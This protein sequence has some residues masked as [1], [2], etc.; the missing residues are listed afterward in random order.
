[1]SFK[2]VFWGVLLLTIGL[3]YALRNFDVIWFSWGA[4]VDLWPLLLLLWGVSLLPVK[5]VFKL[6]GSLGV[7]V[8]AVVLVL[9]HPG[10]DGF[11]FQFGH[12]SWH[13]NND[14]QYNEYSDSD[15][16]TYSDQS[17]S[18]PL[19]HAAPLVKLQLNAAAGRFELSDT[20][21]QLIEFQSNGNI[22][23]YTMTPN[24]GTP[25]SEVEI[26]LD[27]VSVSSGDV[28]NEVILKLNS[29]VTWMIDVEAGASKV[30]MD[31]QPFRVRRLELDGGAS[32]VDLVVGSL[33]DTI[34]IDL[35][36][37]VSELSLAVPQASGCEVRTEAVLSG[38]T[39]KGFEKISTGLYR[40][41]NFNSASKKVFIKAEAAI[42]SIKVERF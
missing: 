34:D 15:S 7:L 2:N 13:Y 20:T 23:P 14:N 32:S 6:A 11:S 18:L 10:S 30:E 21:S 33:M 3:L 25:I 42:S 36:V 31:M 38:R 9:V 22:G 37:G 5:P 1:M 40:T 8:L 4:V 24:D 19:D 39:L 35:E 12:R 26:D 16:D 41:S 17:F 28:K 29:K 27:K